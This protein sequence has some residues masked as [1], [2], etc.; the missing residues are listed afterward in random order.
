MYEP[1][2]EQFEA[3]RPGGTLRRVH[4]VKAGLLAA[5][6]PTELYFFD[7][8]GERWIVAISGGALRAR[9]RTLRYLSREEKIDIAA[10]YLK[11]RLERESAPAA[12]SLMIGEEE[13][14]ECIDWLGVGKGNP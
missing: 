1:A 6:E 14:A 7:A 5:A 13:L 3:T 8:E 12:E 4:F 10:V 9:Q 2:Y 11:K